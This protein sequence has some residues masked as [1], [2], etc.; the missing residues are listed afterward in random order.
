MHDNALTPR[1]GRPLRLVSIA[2]GESYVDTFLEL[3]LPAL[4]APGNLP[5]LAEHFALELVLVTESRFFAKVRSHPA[6]LK[7]AQVCAPRLVEIDDLVAT[8]SSY[9]MS[10]TYAFFRGF[11]DLG[12]SMVGRHVLFIHADFVLAD[13]SYRSLLPHLLSGTPLVFS[14]SYCTIAEDVRGALAQAR[15]ADGTVLAMPPRKM[16]DL[17][18]RNRHFTIRAKTVNQRFFHMRYTDQFYWVVDESTIL[19]HQLPA[20]LVAMK[21][22]K[23]LSDVS[24][25]WDYGL[26][27]EFCP[28]MRYAVLRDSDDFLMMEL[29]DRDTAKLEFELGWPDPSTIAAG[30]A[31]FIT[32]YKKTLGGEQLTLHSGGLPESIDGARIELRKFV[33]EVFSCLPER[34]LSVSGHPQWQHHFGPF[35]AAREQ[36][37]A[38]RTPV[39]IANGGDNRP[40]NAAAALE[41][42]NSNQKELLAPLRVNLRQAFAEL[43]AE[44]SSKLFGPYAEAFARSL[45]ASARDIEQM[46][47]FESARVAL[48]QE[49]FALL[50]LL[51]HESGPEC[52]T[53][54]DRSITT[55][56]LR[57][58]V[59][60]RIESIIDLSARTAAAGRAADRA[61]REYLNASLL[62]FEAVVEGLAATTGRLR[63]ALAATASN[64]ASQRGRPAA[65]PRGR[66]G[67]A[68]AVSQVL[69]GIPPRQRSWH[70]LYAPTRLA[71]AAAQ[72]AI[73]PSKRVLLLQGSTR[74]FDFAHARAGNIVDMP[75]AAAQIP[76]AMR[77]LDMRGG[78]FDVCL[79]EANVRE[80]PVFRILYEEVRPLLANGAVIVCLFLNP[81][82]YEIP[83]EDPQFIRNSFPNC[84]P[85]R[86]AY[87]GSWATA[88]AMRVRLATRQAFNRQVE[89]P[90]T[91]AVAASLLAAAPF[92]TIASLL[93]SGRT[94]DNSFSPPRFI[95]AVTAEIRVG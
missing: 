51:K 87:S 29:R 84:G 48:L 5:A 90:T 78:D 33:D 50:A 16:A 71:F 42:S 26:M 93:E 95:S 62:P 9:G 76:G 44:S 27:S 65:D 67:V 13:G 7:A 40:G 28:S 59:L 30:L 3:C 46:L 36:Y 66:S 55:S 31:T 64:A 73:D 63:E 45:D 79:I 37:I 83:R 2:W 15:S 72:R 14:P 61:A 25:Y 21:P 56:D 88:A 80:L 20:A 54:V 19:A 35:Q 6:F 49:L 68:R 34:L 22:E 74:L 77:M 12:P 24:S 10:L 41:F 92:A 91:G 69:F 86:I 8:R 38:K 18:I 47:L 81:D 17:V 94:L 39:A 75:L 1:R 4:L 70:W 53:R 52:A 89:L 23:F 57:A 43:G 58:E 11:Q 60:R 85:A 32:D 82:L